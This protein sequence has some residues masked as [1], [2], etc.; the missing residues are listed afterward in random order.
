M[1]KKSNKTIKGSGK[2]GQTGRGKTGKGG[3]KGRGKA[4]AALTGAAG[5][6]MCPPGALCFNRRTA[7]YAAVIAVAA[8]ALYVWWAR[9]AWAV[10]L[11]PGVL[12]HGGHGSCGGGCR[13]GGCPACGGHAGVSA[14]TGI[15]GGGLGGPGFPHAEIWPPEGVHTANYANPF[16]P[17]LKPNPYFLPGQK[18]PDVKSLTIGG[19]GLGGFLGRLAAGGMA[20]Q[21]AAPGVPINMSTVHRD[22]NF[23]QVGILTRGDGSDTILPLFGRPLSTGRGRWQYYTMNDKNQPIKLPV[24]REQG[25]CVGQTGCNEV[26]NN[27]SVHVEGYNADFKATIYENDQPQYIPV[28]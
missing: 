2:T 14:S 25:S 21:P 26:F 11:F 8:L 9:P 19:G 23:T 4:L 16:A 13:C 3:Q 22:V 1:P 7:T 5:Y 6:G 17:P 28:V 27:D 24:R 10:R 12:G 18:Q 15:Q 20:T